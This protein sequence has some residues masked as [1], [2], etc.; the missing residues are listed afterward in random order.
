MSLGAAGLVVGGGV[1]EFVVVDPCAGQVGLL[2]GGGRVGVV[3]LL[4]D[5]VEYERGGDDPDAGRDVP[6]VV[7]RA[8]A[9]RARRGRHV[10]S[11]APPPI[12]APRARASRRRRRRLGE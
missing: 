12:H 4:V 8:E 6:R 1:A 9:R 7:V 3:E 10:S 2:A 11:D 5:K